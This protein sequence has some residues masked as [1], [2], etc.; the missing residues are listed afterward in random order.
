MAEVAASLPMVPNMESARKI[1]DVMLEKGTADQGPSEGG[2]LTDLGGEL[3]DQLKPATDMLSRI[4][5]ILENIN[6]NITFMSGKL[7][8]LFGAQN[9]KAEAAAAEENIESARG[10]AP[11]GEADEKEVGV[12]VTQQA[13]GL[14][15]TLFTGLKLLLA[16]KVLKDFLMLNFPNL[17]DGIQEFFDNIVAGIRTFAMPAFVTGIVGIFKGIGKALTALKNFFKPAIM[18]IDTA[19]DAGKSVGVIGKF[20]GSVGKFFGALKMLIPFA[21]TIPGM[22]LIF[23]IIDI[24][25]GFGKGEEEFGGMLGGILGSIRELL[26]GFIG[27]PLDLLKKGVAF[28]LEKMGFEDTA[29]A[30]ESFSFADLIHDMVTGLIN[31][32]KNFFT[33][34]KKLIN[35]IAKFIP[36][37]DGFDIGAE[38]MSKEE[39]AK[40]RADI[41]SG[42]G[43]EEAR[44]KAIE[45]FA[46]EGQASGDR[47][48][49]VKKM[50]VQTAINKSYEDLTPE[51]K[52]MVDQQVEASKAERLK[53]LDA[54]DQTDEEKVI[55]KNQEEE[56][57]IEEAKKE[58]LQKD[59]EKIEKTEEKLAK[60]EVVQTGS[61]L[62]E[63]GQTPEVVALSNA[64]QITPTQVDNSTKVNNNT[65]ATQITRTPPN[66]VTRNDDSS[67]F[68]AV[69]STYTV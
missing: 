65:Q 9:E 25:K 31:F 13:Q 64:N 45:Q 44:K 22:N 63:K 68:G 55:Q 32:F 33:N 48:F 24:F 38:D 54:A 17:A 8:E 2:S 12:T 37:F 7:I 14:F 56:K 47:S 30:L 19:G 35:K 62:K 58:N 67:L 51:Q 43:D 42:A 40:E 23:A 59:K 61:E 57:K 49:E 39:R 20:F 29:E 4:R 53:Q 46:E 11:V 15:S 21:K 60:G 26:V 28:I 1:R 52:A 3:G 36:G 6:G 18:V 34:V 16:G 41:E 69:A 66:I 10:P 50:G 27:L 5:N